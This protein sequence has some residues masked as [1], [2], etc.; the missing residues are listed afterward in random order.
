MLWKEYAHKAFIRNIQASEWSNFYEWAQ[1]EAIIIL[2]II[3][4]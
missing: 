2:E 3:I 1:K 4:L